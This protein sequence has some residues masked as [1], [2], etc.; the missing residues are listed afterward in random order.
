LSGRKADETE[1]HFRQRNAQ[2]QQRSEQVQEK[3][4][5]YDEQKKRQTK[6]AA[7]VERSQE[8][9]EHLGKKIEDAH[10]QWTS[11]RI[12]A[13][14]RMKNVGQLNQDI[15]DIKLTSHQTA[16]ANRQQQRNNMSL[17]DE[18]DNRSRQQQQVRRK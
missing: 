8:A 12:W 6:L 16:H 9:K 5:F 15:G 17:D 11:K 18:I 10:N 3:Q 4:K 1:Q 13:T 14:T 2:L 7:D